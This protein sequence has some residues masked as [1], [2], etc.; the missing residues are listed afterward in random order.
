MQGNQTTRTSHMPLLKKPALSYPQSHKP[1]APSKL[2]VTISNHKLPLTAS[3]Q[4]R[5]EKDK[6]KRTLLWPLHNED[7]K[8]TLPLSS[9]QPPPEI[10]KPQK[11]GRTKKNEINGLPVED[12]KGRKRKSEHKRNDESLMKRQKN[13]QNDISNQLSIAQSALVDAAANGDSTE[14]I[15]S[16]A[17]T[18]R[19]LSQQQKKEQIPT[20]GQIVR[21]LCED[22]YCWAEVMS[23]KSETVL[24]AWCYTLEELLENDG[25]WC[26]SLAHSLECGFLRHKQSWIMRS[27]HTQE[28]HL[29][30]IDELVGDINHVMKEKHIDIRGIVDLKTGAMAFFH[31]RNLN[32]TNHATVVLNTKSFNTITIPLFKLFSRPI[33]YVENVFSASIRSS[34]Q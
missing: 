20:P 31:D 7:R 4:K 17:A 19:S 29:E 25:D 16:L 15:Q 33:L 21:V 11:T 1:C 24:L 2:Q 3:N 5:E 28:V 14:T 18:V 12:K 6:R 32:R 22:R 27:T 34:K 30:S 13:V 9:D 26:R 10:V 8:R 23:T